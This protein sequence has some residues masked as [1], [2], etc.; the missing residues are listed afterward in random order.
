MPTIDLRDAAWQFW[1]VFATVVTAA[2]AITVSIVLYLK[3][4]NTKALAY[5]VLANYAVIATPQEIA[6]KLKVLFDGQEVEGARL[7]VIRLQN[8]G[9]IAIRPEDYY[10]PLTITFPK[11]KR[12]LHSS[13][14]RSKPGNVKL[15][16][17]VEPRRTVLTP[18]L[19][20]R[21]WYVD[22]SCLVAGD[23]ELVVLA[24]QIAE[25]EEIK[26]KLRKR[27]SPFTSPSITFAYVVLGFATIATL[28]QISEYG[29]LAT[30]I[31]GALICAFFIYVFRP[32]PD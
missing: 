3:Q 21:R 5:E 17:T 1:G 18:V 32:N 13:V 24:G 8:T 14:V 15:A 4:K 11:S 12:I 26:E 10:E 20:N 6:G 23:T 22:I 16:L 27:G 2:I 7:V 30:I 29:P 25:V 31:G 28:I 19:L 9:N